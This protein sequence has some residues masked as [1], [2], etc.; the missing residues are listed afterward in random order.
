ME[1]LWKRIEG[2]EDYFV[3][4]MGRVKSSG[5]VGINPHGAEFVFG[6]VILTASVTNWGYERVVLQKNKKRK[7]MRVHRLVAM[8]FIENPE[9]KPQVNHKNGI[10]TDNRAENLE[11]CTAKENFHH[12]VDTGLRP[13]HGNPTGINQYT[14]TNK[15]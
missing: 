2:H 1:E 5:K 12:A 3:S 8:A 6:D 13:E 14:K 9:N 7:H 4:N 15:T 10:K 11:W